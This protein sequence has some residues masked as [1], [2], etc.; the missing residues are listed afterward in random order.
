MCLLNFFY[1]LLSPHASHFQKERRSADVSPSDTRQI[2]NI[3][4]TRLPRDVTPAGY[5]LELQP[6][7]EE[8]EFHGHVTINITC[9]E[10]TDKITLHAH[11]E[12][13]ISESDVGVTYVAPEVPTT[14]TT[15]TTTTEPPVAPV[16][17]GAARLVPVSSSFVPEN[18]C[19]SATS[20]ANAGK[21]KLFAPP[22]SANHNRPTFQD[23][24]I[25]YQTA[26][27]TRKVTKTFRKQRR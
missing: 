3:S 16:P 10:D 9:Q 12:L 14:T 1:A 26:R 18:A 19:N 2:T 8:G 23:I 11:P 27:N 25:P 7:L 6:F 4:D 17:V 21:L 24:P 22:V 13:E 5:R 20:C 15:T